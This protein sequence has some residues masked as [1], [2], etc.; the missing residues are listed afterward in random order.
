MSDDFFTIHCFGGKLG[1]Q[2]GYYRNMLHMQQK[3]I[4]ITEKYEDTRKK[5]YL[6]RA[7]PFFAFICLQ[8]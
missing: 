1:T 5:A 4:P 3:R 2:Q 6:V 8:Q 7:F